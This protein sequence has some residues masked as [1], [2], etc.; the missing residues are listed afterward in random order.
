[1]T[2]GRGGQ[3]LSEQQ[4]GVARAN[5]PESAPLNRCHAHHLK[6][7]PPHTAHEHTHIFTYK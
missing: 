3:K 7:A 1:M 4:S 5:G 6:N 2:K